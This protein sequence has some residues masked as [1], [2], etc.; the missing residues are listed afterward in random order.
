MIGIGK[1]FGSVV[2][3]TYRINKWFDFNF[4]A[5]DTGVQ[6]VVDALKDRKYSDGSSVYD[7]TYIVFTSDNGGNNKN[8]A[9]TYPL[10]GQK[11]SYFEG[12]AWTKL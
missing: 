5:L 12:G 4:I 6:S 8:A 3:L 11:G 7:N 9:S 1:N 2:Q 10:K